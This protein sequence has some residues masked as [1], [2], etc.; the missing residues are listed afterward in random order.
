MFDSKH[1]L[2]TN[3]AGVKCGKMPNAS[4]AGGISNDGN[5]EM[6]VVHQQLERGKKRIQPRI[7]GL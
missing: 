6:H 1:M 3:L 4:K 5:G 7:R 2:K